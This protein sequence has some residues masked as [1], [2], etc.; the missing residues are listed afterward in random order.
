MLQEHLE[1]LIETGYKL[2][3]LETNSPEQT[4]N[5]FRPLIREGKAIYL[6]DNETGLRRMEASHIIIPNTKTPE[7]VLNHIKQSKLY[8][9]YL[10]LGFSKELVKQGLHS[11]LSQIAAGDK[12]N[13]IVIF[14]DSHFNFPH[15]LISK[16]LMAQ[17]PDV[18]EHSS[19]GQI[20]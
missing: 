1:K 16:I 6:W 8:G 12:T 10:L 2:I 14:I 4:I 18:R 3:S 13:K 11:D 5:D 19:L 20:A 9:I 15:A 7:M 17:E